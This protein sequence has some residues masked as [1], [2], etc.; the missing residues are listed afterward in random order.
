M[1]K[2]SKGTNFQ[3]EINGKWNTQ[4]WANSQV[5]KSSSKTVNVA[6]NDTLIY[7][8]FQRWIVLPLTSHYRKYPNLVRTKK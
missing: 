1:L 6:L 8:S 2:D 7:C 4:A 5:T 3:D